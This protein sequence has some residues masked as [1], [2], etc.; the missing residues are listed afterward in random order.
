MTDKDIIEQI[1]Q[2]EGKLS[3]PAMNLVL[4]KAIEE[5]RR[6]DISSLPAYSIDMFTKHIYVT[7]DDHVTYSAVAVIK[8]YRQQH[9]V[10][11]YQ[12][13]LAYD[14]FVNQ[15]QDEIVEA[16]HNYFR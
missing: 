12:A 13:K 8:E 14:E 1:A 4:S 11:L 3:T 9:D 15:H 7:S 10:G 5:L 16:I 2:F 6:T